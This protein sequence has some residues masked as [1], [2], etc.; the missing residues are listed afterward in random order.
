MAYDHKVF[1]NNDLDGVVVVVDVDDDEDDDDGMFALDV[2]F[3]D[4]DD[5][6]VVLDPS[7]PWLLHWCVSIWFLLVLSP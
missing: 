4:D 1:D 7:F 3:H 2:T 6:V 5:V